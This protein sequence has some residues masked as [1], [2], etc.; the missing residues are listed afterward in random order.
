MST[1]PGTLYVVATP[2]GNLDD[3]TRRAEHILREA[4][5]ICCEDTRHSRRL[6]DHLGI[7]G[8][9]VSLHD[10][11]ERARVQQ[12]LGWLESGEQ[13]ALISDA[14]TPLIS[15]PGFIV[16]RD[17]R[18][19]GYPVMPIPG[20]SAVITALSAAGLPTDRFCFEGFLPAKASARSQRLDALRKE[21][22]TL[23]F[24]ESPNR[25]VAL[26][27][28][29]AERL[30]GDRRVIVA[31]ELTKRFEEFI[32]GTAVELA[33]RLSDGVRGE[34]VVMVAGND[35]ADSVDLDADRLL[36]ELLRELPASKAA[37][38]VARLTGGSRKTIYARAVELE[39]S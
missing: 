35:A 20:A 13:V 31:R 17:V 39:K 37:R 14:G 9:L 32:E 2:I 29:I 1:K 19:A 12:L 21:S 15:D 4:D 34:C 36:V 7:S 3:M 33:E 6:L 26:L 5:R 23:I 10:H 18:A 38:I 24:Y 8:Q 30:G 16:V 27:A 11:N 28:D 22:A 25:I